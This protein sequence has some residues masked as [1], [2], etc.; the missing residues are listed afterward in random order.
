MISGMQSRQSEAMR[1][2]KSVLKDLRI[3]LQYKD[4]RYVKRVGELIRVLDAVNPAK[5]LEKGFVKIT[6]ASGKFVSGISSLS[7]GDNVYIEAKDGMAKAEILDVIKEKD[8]GKE[9]R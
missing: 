6:D 3:A 7:K 1:D 8:Y 9:I 2:I 5:I 4:E